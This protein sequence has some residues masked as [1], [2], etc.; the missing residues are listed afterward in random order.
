[1]Q[2]RADVGNATIDVRQYGIEHCASLAAVDETKR[3]HAGAF[4]NGSIV[5]KCDVREDFV[6][7]FVLDVHI[8]G[9]HIGKRFA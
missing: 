8:Y 5:G 7:S 1:M 6:P 3:Y 4:L 9:Y 2:K